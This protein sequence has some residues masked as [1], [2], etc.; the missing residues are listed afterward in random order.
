VPAGERGSFGG[1][2]VYDY[3]PGCRLLAEV[4]RTDEERLE[5]ARNC[6]LAAASA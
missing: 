6:L 5:T 2:F 3:D 1:P 4:E